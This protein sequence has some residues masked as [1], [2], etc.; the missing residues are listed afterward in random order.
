MNSKYLLWGKM[1]TIRK[2]LI[3]VVLQKIKILK[4]SSVWKETSNLY[5]KSSIYWIEL[6]KLSL[7]TADSYHR[8]PSNGQKFWVSDWNCLNNFL[9]FVKHMLFKHG[10]WDEPFST[11]SAC[12]W[13]ELHHSVGLGFMLSHSVVLQMEKQAGSNWIANELLMAFI[14]L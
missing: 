1:L 9:V 7:V 3:M 12:M 11:N 8:H 10:V 5:W 13:H 4:L 14:I 6:F 2:I